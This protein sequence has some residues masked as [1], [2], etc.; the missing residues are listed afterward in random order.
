MTGKIVATFPKRLAVHYGTGRWAAFQAEVTGFFRLL[1]GVTVYWD[2]NSS[3]TESYVIAPG[4]TWD[5][6]S[7]ETRRVIREAIS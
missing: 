2:D 1:T 6:E 4:M 7:A 5:E 3:P